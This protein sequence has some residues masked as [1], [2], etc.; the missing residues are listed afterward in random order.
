VTMVLTRALL[1]QGIADLVAAGAPGLRILTDAERAASLQATLAHRPHPHDGVWLFAYGSLIWNP[2]LEFD[3]RCFA[4]IHGWHRSFCLSTV[5]G[6]GTPEHPGLVLALDR[7]GA[8][9]GAAFHIPEP[10]LA[11][12]LDLLWRRE[13]L[14]G[15]YQPRWVPL[16][17]DNGEALPP[18]IA[19][20]I[21]RDGPF[22]TG[23]LPHA[24]LVRRLSTAAGSLGSSADYL[25]S[26]RD[27]LRAL[28]IHD[29]GIERLATAVEAARTP[30]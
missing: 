26:T 3:R 19:F 30:S 21:R 14:S 9:T 10:L 27:S 22:Y 6:R 7:G 1:E 4:R 16:R 17:T 18:A 24:E 20:T 8:C 2:A 11:R 29:P 5:A 12:E 15:S 23:R 28:G 25:L 13:M